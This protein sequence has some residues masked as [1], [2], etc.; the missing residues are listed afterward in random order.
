MHTCLLLT[1]CLLG[2]PRTV[3]LIELGSIGDAPN[4]HLMGANSGPN[5]YG[6]SCMPGHESVDFDFT[7]WLQDAGVN[8][9]RTHDY[10]GPMDMKVMWFDTSTNPTFPGAMDFD[11]TQADWDFEGCG[12]EFYYN[13]DEVWQ[14]VLDGGFIPYLRIGDS[15]N[16]AIPAIVDF[17]NPVERLRYADAAIRVVGH[18]V[19]DED[20]VFGQTRPETYVEILNEP[21]NNDFW[22]HDWVD[23]EETYKVVANALRGAYPDLRIGGLAVTPAGY[24]V[25]TNQ[26]V[27]V[28]SFI[29]QCQL[30]DTPLDF[31][32]WHMYSD[33]AADF[34]GDG[35]IIVGAAEFYRT[36]LDNYGFTDTESHITEWNTS[37]NRGTWQGATTMARVWIDWQLSGDV[38][39]ATYFR[40]C[41]GTLADQ[42]NQYELFTLDS[43]ET[44]E[45]LPMG[46]VFGALSVLANNDAIVT[47]VSSLP[48]MASIDGDGIISLLIVNDDISGTNWTLDLGTHLIDSTMSVEIFGETPIVYEKD[49]SETVSIPATSVQLVTLYPLPDCYAD[50]DGNGSVDVADVLTLINNWGSCASCP[51]DLNTDGNVDV[52]DLLILISAWGPCS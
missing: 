50:F 15:Y 25:D 49:V 26:V 12:G 48:T 44:V 8:Y 51:Q 20:E 34:I 41:L 19:F 36:V 23:Y 30:H 3:E 22:S 33:D 11:G 43:V 18:F 29:E 17:S 27:H 4:V 5:T 14:D 37:T 45:V 52:G 2:K 9:L 6:E 10:Y 7:P 31:L 1:L 39:V 38:D 13:S 21:D 16:N 28:E 40:S 46:H 32:S 35:D 42:F 47:S 24:M